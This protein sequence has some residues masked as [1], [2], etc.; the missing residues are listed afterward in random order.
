M[1]PAGHRSP[2]APIA[3]LILAGYL[4]LAIFFPLLSHYDR[5]PTLDVRTFAPSLLAGLA[6][7]LLLLLL[8]VAYALAAQLLG[9]S[10]ATASL[11]FLVVTTAIFCL[12]LLLTYPINANDI[13]RYLIRGRISSHYGQSPFVQPPDAFANDPYLPLAGEWAGETSPY[14][15]V[16]EGV[17]AGLAAVA[18]ENLLAGLLLFKGLAALAHLV[19]TVFIWSSLETLPPAERARRA[20][21]WAWNPALLLLFVVDGHNDGLMLLWLLGAWWLLHQNRPLL[22]LA[23]LALGPLTKPIGALAIP[24]FLITW[25]RRPLPIRQKLSQLVIGASVALLLSLLAFLPFGSPWA[26]AG[27]LWREAGEAGGFSVTALLILAGR[28]AD[29]SPPVGL[30]TGTATAFF[31]LAGAY[32]LWR[33]WRGGSSLAGTAALFTAYIVQAFRFRIWYTVWPFPFLL[34]DPTAG[35]WLSASLWLLVTAQLSTIL[36]GHLRVFLLGSSQLWAHLIGVPFT[37][38]LPLLLAYFSTGRAA[39]SDV[40]QTILFWL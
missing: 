21:L 8:F 2:L 19:T 18:G 6:Y 28:E 33:C 10:R 13:Y 40:L 39:H 27:R 34:L 22:A 5:A 37:F 12:P 1:A 11:R 3:L 24:F 36:Y 14:G 17:A 20:L 26:L 29:L 25:M 15:P 38:G 32:I 31:L 23:L 4:L 7:G 9:R 30:I 16:W 35:H